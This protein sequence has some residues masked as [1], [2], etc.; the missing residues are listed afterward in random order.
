M[1]P[2]IY[3]I[4]EIICERKRGGKIE[5]VKRVERVVVS[6]LS[7]AKEIYAD[8]KNDAEC[9]FQYSKYLGKVSLFIPKILPNGEVTYWGEEKSIEELEK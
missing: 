2:T 3:K 6:N 4:V 5:D 8:F 1:E 7:R 9:F